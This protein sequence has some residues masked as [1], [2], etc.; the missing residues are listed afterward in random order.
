MRLAESIEQVH[1]TP[2]DFQRI[3]SDMN[4]EQKVMRTNRSKRAW[5][6]QLSTEKQAFAAAAVVT[7]A[8]VAA[9]SC[10]G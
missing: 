3:I 6:P 10:C 5:A 8:A 4:R 9:F 7:V 1:A 2:P